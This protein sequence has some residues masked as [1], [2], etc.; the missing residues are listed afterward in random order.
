MNGVHVTLVGTVATRPE[1]RTANGTKLI[2]FR[3]VTNERRFD[4]ESRS[5]VDSAQTWVT[6]TCWRALAVNVEASVMHRDRVV[7]HGRMRTEEWVQDGVR[8]S[9]V[10]VTADTVGHDLGFG[11]AVFSRRS[12][13]DEQAL[14]ALA[15]EAELVRRVTDLPVELL[16]AVTL[17]P[18]YALDRPHAGGP[19]SEPDEPDEFD[20][21]VE[22]V[23]PQ[24][25]DPDDAGHALVGAGR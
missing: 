9:G 4:R 22:S 20:E 13:Q 7:V 10:A 6:V 19:G 3:M 16:E 8:R 5:W 25:E 21:P 11:T 14:A 17:D 15:V 2:S 1:A 18:P 12:R 24:L 23:D